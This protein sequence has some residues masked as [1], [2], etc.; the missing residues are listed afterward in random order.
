MAGMC[1]IDVG[2]NAEK[3]MKAKT[4]D[5]LRTHLEEKRYSTQVTASEINTEVFQFM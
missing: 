2:H 1:I 3:I 5:W 4:A